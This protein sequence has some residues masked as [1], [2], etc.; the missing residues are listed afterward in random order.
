MDLGDLGSPVPGGQHVPHQQSLQVR[1]SV[2][3]LGEALVGV[4]HPDVFRLA[5]VDAAAQGPAAV[6]IRAVV[7]PAVAAEEALPAESLHVHRHPVSRLKCRDSL[8]HLLHHAHHL[9]SHR[10]A[11]H[12]PGHGAVKDVQVAG[13]DAAQGDF[14]D[15]VPGMAQRGFGL[16][17]QLELPGFYIGIGQ[18]RRFL[19]LCIHVLLLIIIGG[20]CPV[21]VRRQTKK[22]PLPLK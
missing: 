12:R 18:H 15:G 21:N 3:D 19:L 10:N 7:D 22:P 5:A 6:G 13:A 4:G 14:D 9:V 16:V 20:T 1:D 8:P 17:Q 11:G 2:G